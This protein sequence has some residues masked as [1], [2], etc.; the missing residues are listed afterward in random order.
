MMSFHVMET[1]YD[2]YV[3]H[4]N[5]TMHPTMLGTVAWL[6]GR[7]KKSP[8][9]F[10]TESM[11]PE[12]YI[13]TCLGFLPVHNGP[14]TWTLPVSDLEMTRGFGSIVGRWPNMY[15][16]FERLLGFADLPSTVA[17][18]CTALACLPKGYAD[19]VLQIQELPLMWTLQRL[20]TPP[21]ERRQEGY[22]VRTIL[23]DVKPLV[24]L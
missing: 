14:G 11:A 6:V 17:Y 9:R 3:N 15:R 5:W 8:Q 24:H 4:R 13:G 21:I 7:K 2:Q 1:T 12:S 16:H 22:D 19:T 10:I 23:F 20:D 18:S